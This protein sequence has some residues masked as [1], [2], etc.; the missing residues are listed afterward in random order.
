MNDPLLAL[1]LAGH[2]DKARAEHD[3][4]QTFEDFRPDNDIGDAR[5]VL[6]RHEDDAR[7]GAWPLAHQH[8]PSH[9]DALAVLDRT[10]RFR[11][12]DSTRGKSGA[13]ERGW[14]SLERQGQA[15]IILDHMRAKRHRRQARVRLRL[16]FWPAGE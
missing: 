4:A 15:P 16:V 6:Q 2:R 10:Q 11:A 5:L 12:Q 3:C 13:Q 8:E 14:M 7:G 1:Q 9:R